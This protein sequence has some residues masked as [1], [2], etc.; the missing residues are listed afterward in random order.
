MKRVLL[1]AAMVALLSGPAA[2]DEIDAAYAECQ[3]IMNTGLAAECEVSGW[4][5]PSTRGWTRTARRRARSARA[6][7]S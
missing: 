3:S 5:G 6:W 2:G 4:D 7:C 1:I